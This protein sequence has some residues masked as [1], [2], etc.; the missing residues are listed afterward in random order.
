MTRQ[1]VQTGDHAHGRTYTRREV[2]YSAL[3]SG[4]GVAVASVGGVWTHAPSVAGAASTV[5]VGYSKAGLTCEGATFA[6]QAQGYFRDEG[7]DLT[8]LA[9]PGPSELASEMMKGNVGAMQ[10]PAWTLVPGLLPQG[11]HVGDMV[12]T[13]GLQRGSMSLVV[14]ASSAIRSVADLRGVKVS[15][16]ARWRWMFGQPLQV[17]GLN[18]RQDVDWQPPLPPTQVAAALTTQQVAAAAVHQPYAA[19]A[20]RLLLRRHCPGGLGPV[21]SSEGGGD[22]AGTHAGERLGAY[23]PERECPAHD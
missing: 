2:L 1:A 6:A 12:A 16:G 17:A 3:R 4:I 10:D 13:A 7:L 8:T 21:R 18:P 15:A 14:P 9:L 5:T 23:A 20:R 11:M 22:H 19:A